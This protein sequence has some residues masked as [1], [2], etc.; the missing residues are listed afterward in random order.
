MSHN[1]SN[2]ETNAPADRSTD[3]QVDLDAL[4]Q[5]VREGDALSARLLI[6][7]LLA[8]GDD[9]SV[10]AAH[11][12]IS[13]YF[14]RQA[15]GLIR[16]ARRARG[17]S[18]NELTDEALRA[19]T[20]ALV[21]EGLP[22]LLRSAL[23]SGGN[24]NASA[25]SLEGLDRDLA[26]P[27]VTATGIDQGV[28]LQLVYPTGTILP[29]SLRVVISAFDNGQKIY[30]T[31][32]LPVT[33]LTTTYTVN[34]LVNGKSYLFV[35][36]LT[37]PT[38][39]IKVTAQ[40]GQIN[41]DLP[42]P[43]LSSTP[44][45]NIDQGLKFN[46]TK[47]TL[48]TGITI[49]KYLLSLTGGGQ[50]QFVT[51]VPQ[52]GSSRSA[53]ETILND[54][55]HTFSGLQNGLIYSLKLQSFGNVNTATDQLSQ[56]VNAIGVPG[57]TGTPF[58]P[59]LPKLP[60]DPLLFLDSSLSTAIL[61]SEERLLV[62][63]HAIGQKW[64]FE[65]LKE[66][67]ERAAQDALAYD[68][69]IM[70]FMSM[71]L[72]KGAAAGSLFTPVLLSVFD[73]LKETTQLISN[74]SGAAPVVEATGRLSNAIAEALI[75]AALLRWLAETDAF[76][77]WIK[78]FD[79]LL[80][81]ITKADTSLSHVKDAIDSQYNEANSEFGKTIRHLAN[82]AMNKVGA[83]V[84]QLLQPLHDAV[85]QIIGGASKEMGEVFK[86]FDLPLLMTTRVDESI[87]PGKDNDIQP[88]TD[89]PNVNPLVHDLKKLDEAVDQLEYAIQMRLQETLL[90]IVEGTGDKWLHDLMTAYLITPLLAALTIAIT[91]GPVSAALLAA[92]IAVA[93]EELLHLIARWLLGPLKGVLNDLNRGVEEAM[94]DFQRA[95]SYEI[96]PGSL[97]DST[98]ALNLLEGELRQLRDLL[99]QAFLV[100]LT[101]LLADVR[102]LTLAGGVVHALAAERALGLANGTAFDRIHYAYESHA[103]PAYQMPG[104]SDSALFAGA[105]LLRDLNL[106]EQDLV[107]LTDGKEV[108]VR[109]RLSLFQLLGGVGDPLTAT[110]LALGRFVDF[111]CT[112]QAVIDLRP[113]ALLDS[114]APG[115]YRALI[116]DVKVFALAKPPTDNSRPF[117]NGLAVTLSHDG[118][119]RTRIKRDSNPAAP[120]VTLPRVLPDRE[121]YILAV[122]CRHTSQDAEPTVPL[123]PNSVEGRV[124]AVMA[125]MQ[126]KVD[127]YSIDTAWPTIR[128]ALV[129][130]LPEA[131]ADLGNICTARRKNATAS[132]EIPG[133]G[134][135]SAIDDDRE[136]Y[137]SSQDFNSA[138]T[139]VDFV[140]ELDWE[141]SGVGLKKT[142]DLI[143][144]VWIWPRV[145][146]QD[147]VVGF[148]DQFNLQVSN[149]NE[150]SD[151]RNIVVDSSGTN[152]TPGREAYYYHFAPV[153]G[154]YLR[155]HATKLN[156]AR[157][158]FNLQ[159][160]NVQIELMNG[161]LVPV[162]LPWHLNEGSG[163]D[164]QYPPR[165]LTDNDLQTYFQS[166]HYSIEKPDPEPYFKVRGTTP[167]IAISR[168]RI[169]PRQDNAEGFPTGFDIY[170]S[171]PS[172]QRSADDDY[173]DY[174]FEFRDY[175]EIS[176]TEPQDFYIPTASA[177]HIKFVGKVLRQPTDGTYTM[178]IAEVEV[179]SFIPN[180]N[181]VDSAPIRNTI[182]T[183]L[184]G[185]IWPRPFPLYHDPAKS[186]VKI[187]LYVAWFLVDF[188]WPGIPG[189]REMVASAWDATYNEMIG[190]LAKWG[191]A[192]QEEDTD[193]NVRALNY[194][195][196][197]RQVGPEAVTFDLFP[198]D[199]EVSSSGLFLQPQTSISETDA[200]QYRPFENL[201]IG[202]QVQIDVPQA[203]TA[204]IAD[205]IV[206]IT[207]RGCFDP[208]LA[209]TV[210]A[211]QRQRNY[212]IT[213]ANSARTAL[214]LFLTPA[215]PNITGKPSGLRTVR[216]SLR[217][218]RDRVLQAAIAG[219]QIKEGTT[220]IP[221]TTAV[222][223]SGITFEPAN[224]TPLA[225]HEPF[226][227]F[228]DVSSTSIR[229]KFVSE[230]TQSL[231]DQLSE[232]VVTPDVLGVDLDLLSLF[233]GQSEPAL[234]AIA[235]VL[236]PTRHAVSG[237]NATVGNSD[238]DLRLLLGWNA[239]EITSLLSMTSPGQ[240]NSRL[241]LTDLWN[242]SRAL[243]LEFG[244]AIASGTLYDVIFG[245]SFRFPVL[246]GVTTAPDLF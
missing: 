56:S 176:D 212:Q 20:T 182:E 227:F 33:A 78:L 8:S 88:G 153:S 12:A 24:V 142:V 80:K 240:E 164:P 45:V 245:L 95:L 22:Q 220:N 180:R 106:L 224:V 237:F 231:R 30:E 200:R 120:P 198:T 174:K 34:S 179:T 126:D 175:P 235:V 208:D 124:W 41:N 243:Q 112:G 190:H 66:Q 75:M 87:Q 162:S 77:L 82:I 123:S 138:D 201:G 165:N 61:K 234:E 167:P 9:E 71:T 155:I 18:K 99:P 158:P 121:A 206:E 150:D 43:V 166:E 172:S 108:E 199:H 86:S 89:I 116:K 62:E 91:G 144:G 204:L 53:G 114:S 23:Q 177:D 148:P 81:D 93:A 197:V 100:D 84:H 129:E 17:E 151:Y 141:A 29:L 147:Q 219:A 79:A 239:S 159:L 125:N 154:R 203:A 101:G 5:G 196:L 229:L 130:Q 118:K 187:A 149:V 189:L 214:N 111:L 10:R 115:V 60:V 233:T 226:S 7:H 67:A 188:S 50:T 96:P 32:S 57:L 183:I 68:R 39:P 132:S 103:A 119:S 51:V 191:D 185:I 73:D 178:E 171:R 42:S 133:H 228:G 98:S 2:D 19:F 113:E 26:P 222:T 31:S 117:T 21:V 135:G 202:G 131:I 146:D 230:A 152:T 52:D 232:I 156:G 205:L 70:S 157:A 6:E 210:R 184:R 161:T 209:S 244:N 107:H 221:V 38:S 27:T 192:T 55:S 16:K 13:R 238:N 92:V 97:L 241:P 136:T 170:L 46:W 85:A 194:V 193:P 28:T 246:A 105:R 35:V 11:R 90:S 59:R 37:D 15:Q 143:T 14:Q 127:W 102:D 223:V 186:A 139:I 76:E 74:V 137:Y 242:G 225:L 47:P 104:G 140:V 163:Y 109:R 181:P 134:P 215:I 40:A 25:S 122:T 217:T 48:G 216:F 207:M 58:V 110:G 94:A 160:S 1:S 69:Q 54:Y 195:N 65:Y 211:G 213:Q 145:D 44:V 3:E 64:R 49:T 173:P 63:A 36:Q 4:W 72:T 218:Q 169:F 128:K 236:I 168:I 83:E